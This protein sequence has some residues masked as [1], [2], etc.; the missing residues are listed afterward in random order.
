MTKLEVGHRVRITDHGLQTMKNMAPSSGIVV[1]TVV[2]DHRARDGEEAVRV[3]WDVDADKELAGRRG[4]VDTTWLERAPNYT[5]M[6]FSIDVETD[7]PVPGLYSMLSIGITAL[8]PETLVEVD[9]F[10]ATLTPLPGAGEHPDTM[11]W[12]KEFPERY[13][14][15]IADPKDPLAVMTALES[16]VAA[17][18]DRFALDGVAPKPLL[19]AYPIA[20]DFGF[21]IYYAHRFAGGARFGFTGLDM[22]SWAMGKRGGAYDDQVKKKWPDEWVT[23]EDRNALHNALLDARQQADIF[24]RQLLS[25]LT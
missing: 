2:D 7:G 24:R 20:F 21:Y 23:P 25:A 4:T 5:E 10:Y 6:Y 12:W 19:V 16:W 8:H 3:K 13:A 11:Q 17:T 14:E 22:A 15:A 18:V 9:S 1:G